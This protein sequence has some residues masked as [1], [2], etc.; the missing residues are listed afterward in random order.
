QLMSAVVIALATWERDHAEHRGCALFA[1]RSSGGGIV[2]DADGIYGT[3]DDNLNT[4][5]KQQWQQLIWRSY[6]PP[7]LLR[8]WILK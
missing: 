3:A 1:V 4:Q 6:R 7:R 8:R 5:E 2:R